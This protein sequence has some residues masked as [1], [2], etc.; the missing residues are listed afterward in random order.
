MDILLDKLY[1]FLAGLYLAKGRHQTVVVTG[2]VGKTSTTQA[3]ATVLGESFRVKTTR[4]NYNTHRGV[5]LTVFDLDIPLKRVGWL[6]VTLKSAMKAIFTVPKF[7]MLVLELGSDKPGDVDAFGFLHPDLAVVTAV[8]PEHMEYFKT[9]GAVAKEELS[10]AKFSS[11]VLINSSLVDKEYIAKYATGTDVVEYCTK[12]NFAVEKDSSVAISIEGKV[13]SVADPKVIS[14][15]GTTALLVAANVAKHFSMDEPSIVSGLSKV[16]PVAGRMSRL[17]G[18]NGSV[19][20]DDTYNS[21]PEAVRVA[22]DYLYTR[23]EKQKIVV[24]GNMNEMGDIS[25]QLHTQVGSWCDPKQIGLLVTIGPEANKYLATAAEKKGCK[26]TRVDTPYQ[27]GELVKPM[28]SPGTVVLAKG[29]QNNVYLEE[30]VKYW[31]ADPAGESKLTRQHSYWP[32]KKA[33][34][35]EGK[36]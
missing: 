21:S 17:A 3:I 7:D 28:L 14:V 33:K 19:I 8:T 35:F 25:E 16:I 32:A 15:A 26:V 24:L 30:A 9:I 4:H 1:L 22:L 13:L 6:A 20:I 12:T 5:P 23:S 31:L 2:S 34:C 11:K 18:K 10:V 27:A 36:S 29:S